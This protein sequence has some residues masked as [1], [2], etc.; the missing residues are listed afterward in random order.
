MVSERLHGKKFWSVQLADV[1]HRAAE[2]E[3]WDEKQAEVHRQLGPALSHADELMAQI[4]KDHP[5]LAPSSATQLSEALRRRAA[6]IEQADL[7]QRLSLMMREQA[8]LFRRC[9]GAISKMLR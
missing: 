3:N 5:E 2:A 1:Q 9:E 4:H 7:E 8:A 6:D